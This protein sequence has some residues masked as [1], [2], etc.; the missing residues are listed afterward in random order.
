MLVCLEDAVLPKKKDDL[1]SLEGI[2]AE[3]AVGMGFE[4]IDVELARE[5]QGLF[6]R[7]YIDKPGGITID[8]CETYHKS[9]QKYTDNIDFDYM[10]VS[11]P[12]IDRPLKKDKDFARAEGTLVEVKLYKA[13]NGVKLYRGEL[14]GL[15]YEKIVIMGEEGEEKAFERKAVASVRPVVEFDESDLEDEI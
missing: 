4:L 8:D 1:L 3:T 9:V 7:F 10:E 11:S 2:A 15:R 13:E 12:G 14:I 5:P 6:L